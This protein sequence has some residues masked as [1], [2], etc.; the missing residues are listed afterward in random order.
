MR[1]QLT[2]NRDDEGTPLL[3]TELP[4]DPTPSQ[5]LKETFRLE[6][7]KSLEAARDPNQRMS[8][9]EVQK[10]ATTLQE[11]EESNP[12][13]TVDLSTLTDEELNIVAWAR[14]ILRKV[15]K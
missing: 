13:K 7:N 14:T 11:F 1:R 10:L 15:L 8:L 6:L 4:P 9:K 12:K 3:P 2:R 5:I